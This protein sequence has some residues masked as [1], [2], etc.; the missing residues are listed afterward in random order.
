[1]AA[2]SDAVS[3]CW[4]HPLNATESEQRNIPP[5]P[6]RAGA[7]DGSMTDSMVTDSGTDMTTSKN[8]AHETTTAAAGH[9]LQ[10]CTC[11]WAKITS[12][13]G[14][15]THQGKRGCLREQRQ[16][17]RI[18]QYF[19]RS[20]QS[21]QS[22]EAQ[23]REK[24]QSSQSI[25]TSV[26]EEDNTSTEM[27]VE[28]PTQPQRPPKEEK[29][30]G[31]RPS[32]KWP[33][34]VEK[35]EWEITNNDL[36]KILEQQVG[37]AEKKLE[38][39]VDIIYHYGEERFGVNARRS[40]KAISA[41]AKSRRQQEIEILV[42]ERRQLRKQWKKASDAEREGLMLL[43]G[44]IKCRLATL[45]RAENLRK[46]RKKKEHTR[47]RFYKNPFKFV[48]DLFAKEKSGI[49]KIPK[50]ELEEHLEKGNHD[51]KR[52]EQI[53]IPHDIPPIQPPEFNLET[54]PPKWK[55]VES[56]VRRAR[57]A[58][59][60]GPNGVPYKLYKN[61]PDV[62]RYLWRLMRIVWQKG[63]IPKGWRR[64][65]GVLI[66]KEKDATDIGQFRPICLLNVEGKIF[67][68]VIARRLST[69]LEKNKY[70]DTSVQKAGIPGV[71]GCLEHTSMIWHQ[72]QAAKKDKRDIHVIFLD[73]AN[74]FGSVPH[75]L[76]WESFNFFHVPASVTNLVKAYFED[77]QLCF[78]T[79]DFTTSWQ[80]VEVGIMAGCTISPLAFTMAMEVIIRAS[81]WVVGGERTKNGIRLPPIRAYMDDMTTLTT[82]AA[83]TRRLL[84]KLQENIKWARMKIKP[85]KSRSISI[86]KGQLKNVK[87]CIGDDPI[88]TVSEQPVKSLGRWYNA[89]LGDKDQVQQVRQDITNSLEDIN[90]TLLP[91]KLKLWCLQFGLLPRVMWPLTVYELPITT[92]EKMER[93]MT[94][95]IKKWLGVP[96]CLTNISLYG[97]GVLELPITSLTEEYKC[98]KVRLQMTLKDSRDQTIS[99]AVPLLVTGRKWTPSDAVQQ[100]TSALK[101]SDIVGHVQLGRG[102]FGLT[103]SKPTWRKASTSERRKMVV[104]EVRRQEETERSAKAVSLVRQGQWMRWEGLER[105]KLSWRELWE[106]EASNISFIIRATYD[107]LPSPKNLNQWYG[108]D[109]TC[110]LCPTPATLK[111][112][113]AGCK[114][115]LTQGRYTWRHNQVLKSLAAA[116]ESQ[117]NT[118]NSLPLRAIDS[119]TAPTFIREGQKK[120]KHPPT[121]TEAGQL[122]MARDW[123]MLVDIGQQ[124]IF[125]PE[126]A[127]TT[128]RP[129]LVLWSPS[130]K[131]VYIIEL[132]VPWENS[133]NEAYERKKLRY[134]EL[135]ADAQ[136][137]GWKAKVYPV[138]VGC[139]GFVASSTIRLLKDLGI[140]GQALRQTIK[141]V[142]E[143]AERSSQWIWIKRK[144][145][146]W[147]Q[148]A[149][150]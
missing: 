4:R 36:T 12:F 18:D 139:R 112:I 131:T 29:I 11:G 97:K 15:R 145:P 16:G 61:A 108:E 45:R 93:T 27:P 69:Y 109:P 39:M 115:C 91:G 142:S 92:V 30:K 86:V 105:R 35:R 138:E 113:L 26:P 124:L 133:T 79:A 75:N 90:S 41:P 85:N 57:S 58:S 119:I 53:V 7:Q 42:R 31:H 60:P 37:T 128:L 49:L 84:G 127:V 114:T 77:L 43:Q 122:A 22:I 5:E 47:T 116:L 64:A 21:N 78:T 126:I 146:C 103:A 68:S 74:A 2:V 17:P 63:I 117:R 94:S 20:N 130:L 23:R 82:T 76:L 38:R 147:A 14:L 19:L 72:I 1:M 9:S 96:R 125:P 100:A 101:H 99:N 44:D 65:G 50:E 144:D 51:P 120:P 59:A 62:L 121:K 13:R 73:L 141:S 24:N 136:Q 66:P 95:Y 46:L 33:K 81:R 111:H 48:K 118:T 123:K 52:H 70:I 3:V 6:A 102:G 54:G 40:N 28:E 134:I 32:V 148:R 80:R 25:S 143:A 150:T 71:S 8:T 104:E 34:A 110:A 98:S 55:E 87:F 83:C 149:S 135:A 10:V 67:F 56:T 106:M 137:R 107:V 89:S 88:P 129:D 140:H 132:T